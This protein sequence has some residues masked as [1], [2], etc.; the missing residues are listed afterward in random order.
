MNEATDSVK[1]KAS[2]AVRR[3][4]SGYA[5]LF[6]A[7]ALWALAAAAAVAAAA[8]IVWPLWALATRE[9]GIFNALVAVLAISLAAALAFFSLRRRLAS[10]E[11]A[12]SVLVKAM[13]AFAIVLALLGVIASAYLCAAFAFRGIILGALPAGLA[14]LVLSGWLFFGRKRA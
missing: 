1:P 8:A 7:V 3:I 13:K 5:R 10:G 14:A 9:R 6:A 2:S 4:A 11:K 12:R